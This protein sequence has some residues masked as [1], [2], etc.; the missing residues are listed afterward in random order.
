MATVTGM[1]AAAMQAIRDGT[2][3]DADFDSAGHLIFTKY[4]GTQFDAGAVLS[5]TTAQSGV[6][7]LATSA[8]T[9]TGTDTQRAVTPAG[10]ASIPGNKVQ[11][12]SA[13]P[14]ESATPTS[15]PTGMSMMLL[16]GTNGWSVNSSVGSVITNNISVDRTQQTFYSNP[17]GVGNPR[18]WVRFHHSTNNGG[19]WTAWRQVQ[20]M[21]DLAVASFTQATA[22]TSYPSGP[23]RLYFTT[24][25]S[26]GWDFAGKAGEV[27]TYTDG[28]DF[29]R[30]Q[31]TKH[32]GGSSGQTEIWVRTA[33][34]ASG[35]SPWRKISRDALLADPIVYTYNNT[36]TITAS[37]WADHPNNVTQTL[38]LPYDAIVSVELHAWL[39]VNYVDASTLRMGVSH[40]GA[41]PDAS[42]GSAWGN[43][44]YETTQGTA[45]G[46]GQHGMSATTKLSAGSNT[47]KVQAY[48]T[49]SGATTGNYY[50][51]R[52]TPLRWAE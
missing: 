34:T 3:V 6:V 15:Y 18:E 14:A 41:T 29:A 52:I 47:F 24:S 33:N 20:I 7:E 27:L 2:V 23:S 45:G 31:W 44:L 50:Q 40:N 37:S 43:V 38:V 19:G 10:L 48:K 32:Q 30:Q 5:A 51:L 9:Q 35:W 22:F 49:G 1:T 46:G 4:D 42:L 13:V 17:G 36:A 39:S 21:N 26:S 8:E 11:I 25:T 28:S 16:D 12:L